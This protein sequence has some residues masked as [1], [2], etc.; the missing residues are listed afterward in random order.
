MFLLVL[1]FGSAWDTF[2]VAE[3]KPRKEISCSS[4]PHYLFHSEITFPLLSSAEVWKNM[5]I[6]ASQRPSALPEGGREML[7]RREAGLQGPGWV[8]CKEPLQVSSSTGPGH[9]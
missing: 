1:P 7:G 5:L 4:P 2:P 8:C 9:P 3:L 6:T